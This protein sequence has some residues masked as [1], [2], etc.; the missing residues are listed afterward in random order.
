MSFFS[1]KSGQALIEYLLL[2]VFMLILSSR[3][4]GG[5]TTFMR[6]SVG[7]LG[8]ILSINLTVGVCAKECFFTDYLN[9]FRK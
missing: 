3:L 4:V 5:F 1:K 9:G 8:H 2:V 7:N 6:D